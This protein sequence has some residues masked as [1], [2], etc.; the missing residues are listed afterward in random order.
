MFTISTILTSLIPTLIF[1]NCLL[2]TVNVFVCAPGFMTYNADP[3]QLFKGW[4][5]EEFIFMCFK[6]PSTLPSIAG[7]QQKWVDEMTATGFPRPENLQIDSHMVGIPKKKVRCISLP[8]DRL[9]SQELRVRGKIC[10]I[11]LKCHQR[12][13]GHKNHFSSAGSKLVHVPVLSHPLALHSC[14]KC[15]KIQTG[16][17]FTENPWATNKNFL[18]TCLVETACDICHLQLRH[19]KWCWFGVLWSVKLIKRATKISQSFW[20]TLLSMIVQDLLIASKQLR[21]KQRLCFP[22][23]LQPLYPLNWT[24]TACGHWCYKN[25][26]C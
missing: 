26:P 13:G 7:V 9:I 5:H 18:H 17:C 19:L 14:Y 10:K 16:G 3:W 21:A 20:R 2:L 15:E 22:N 24:T 12:T 11:M 25:H 4:A 1:I 6:L 23:Y 8:S